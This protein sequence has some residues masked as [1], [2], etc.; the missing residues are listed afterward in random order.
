MKP[1]K[2]RLKGAEKKF[3]EKKVKEFILGYSPVNYMLALRFCKMFGICGT[4]AQAIERA[5]KQGVLIVKTRSHKTKKIIATYPE[6]KNE[7]I[8]IQTFVI[9]DVNKI[10]ID[11]FITVILSLMDNNKA[12]LEQIFK[13]NE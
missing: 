4:F 1:S 7:A 13:A 10:N 2:T 8:K 11:K 3:Y 12:E 6:L 9:R 5:Y